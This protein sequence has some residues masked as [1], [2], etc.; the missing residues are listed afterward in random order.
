MRPGKIGHTSIASCEMRQNLPARW[1]GERS[2]SSV[3]CL[4][5]IFNHLVNYLAEAIQRANIFSI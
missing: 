3:Q 2:K 5:R 4:G 1:I